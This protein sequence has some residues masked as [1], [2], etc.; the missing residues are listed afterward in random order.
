VTATTA[1]AQHRPVLPLLSLIVASAAAAISVV[2]IATDDVNSSPSR[3]IVTA[4]ADPTSYGWRLDENFPAGLLDDGPP[5]D[6]TVEVV[7]PYFYGG[8]S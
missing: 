4:Q 5:V 1:R 6:R 2:A 7:D 8:G 3:A